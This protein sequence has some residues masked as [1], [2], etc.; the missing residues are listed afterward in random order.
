[1]LRITGFSIPDGTNNKVPVQN[2]WHFKLCKRLN[3]NSDKDKL[4]YSLENCI[5]RD[6]SVA[7][8]AVGRHFL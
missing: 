4:N 6:Y 5:R 1:L 8:T 2:A 3:Q 7:S